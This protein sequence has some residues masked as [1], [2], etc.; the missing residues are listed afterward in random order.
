M[1]DKDGKE[2][3]ERKDN[4]RIVGKDARTAIVAVDAYSLASQRR[5]IAYGRARGNV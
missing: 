5:A 3:D 1:S 2:K 4:T